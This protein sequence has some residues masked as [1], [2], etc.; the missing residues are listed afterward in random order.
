MSSRP[1][2]SHVVVTGTSGA[3]GGALAREVRVRYPSAH[4]TLVDVRSEETHALGAELGNASSEIVDLSR[5]DVVP[6]LV[7]RAEARQGAIDG[8]INAAGFMD[9]R[10]LERFAWSDAARLLDVDLLAPLRLL[11]AVVPSMSERGNGFVVNVTSMAGRVPLRGC[12]VY[13]AAKAGL[14]MASEIAHAELAERGVRVV[15]VYP[16]PVASRLEAAAR[17]QFE[18]SV[19]A[20]A[21]PTGQ[22]RALARRVLDAVRDGRARVVYPS[23]YELGYR[24]VNLA[25]RFAL[26]L[27]PEPVA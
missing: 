11:H 27:G 16:G 24:A 26:A 19:L 18:R 9:V 12:S 22:A 1:S 7:E 5:A 2:V 15:T 8:L 20:R 3:I 25:S 23:I 14:S 17:A 13:G 10:R 21:V 4:L 6:N